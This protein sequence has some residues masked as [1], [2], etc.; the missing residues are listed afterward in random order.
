[1]TQMVIKI[2]NIKITETVTKFINIAR[3]LVGFSI[4]TSVSTWLLLVELNFGKSTFVFLFL[5]STVQD[6]GIS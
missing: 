6:V 5:S 2:M 3:S 1:M 4:K